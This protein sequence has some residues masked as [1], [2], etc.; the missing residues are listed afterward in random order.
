MGRSLRTR[1]L[2]ALAVSAL[3]AVATV[4]SAGAAATVTLADWRMDEPAGATVMV[5]ASGH[6][7]DGAIGAAVTTG[8]VDGAVTGYHWAYTQPNAPPPKPERLIQVAS[9]LLDP[10]SGDYAITIRFRTSKSFG[11]IIQKGQSGSPTGYFKWQIPNGK[12]SCLFRGLSPT[13]ETLT[14]SVS[15]GTTLLNDGQWHTV[16]CERTVDRV[17]MTIDGS[18][19]RKA[20]GPTG[21]ITNSVPLTIGGKLNCDQV[22]VTCD[23]FVGDIDFV[24]IE[25]G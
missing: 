8:S 16:R 7:L 12:L 10:G 17:T 25:T 24:T 20:I 21:T 9:G 5:D 11:N 2:T 6:G 4:P 3:C 23:Y 19:T 18:I 14:R 15:S 1:V 22:E 13:G